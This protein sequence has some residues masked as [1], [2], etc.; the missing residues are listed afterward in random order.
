MEIRDSYICCLGPGALM[1][2]QCSKDTHEGSI[3]QHSNTATDPYCKWAQ[4][5][6]HSETEVVYI[7]DNITFISCL[8]VANF[9]LSC[10]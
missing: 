9:M 2:L 10:T 4:A 3:L 6:L 8:Y 1:Q 7:H 5:N